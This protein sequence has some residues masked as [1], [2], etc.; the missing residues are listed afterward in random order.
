M[1]RNVR[2]PGQANFL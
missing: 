2:S 1:L